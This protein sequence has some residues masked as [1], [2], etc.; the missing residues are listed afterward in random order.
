VGDHGIGGPQQEREEQE[1]EEDAGEF[2]G[3]V[4][5]GLGTVPGWRR[6]GLFRATGTSPPRVLRCAG[7]GLMSPGGCTPQL[8]SGILWR[9]G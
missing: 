1:G 7:D 2:H 8:W 9:L 6:E 5:D 4:R 3:L